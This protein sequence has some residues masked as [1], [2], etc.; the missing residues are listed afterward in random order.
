[1]G[2]AAIKY[3]IMPESMETDLDALKEKVL[4]A[5][6]DFAQVKGAEKKPVAFGLNSL[7]MMIVMDDKKG[8]LDDLEAAIAGVEGVQSVDVLEM[9]LL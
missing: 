7:E 3:K 2:E 6:P 4:S 1:M 8:G 9:G 5:I